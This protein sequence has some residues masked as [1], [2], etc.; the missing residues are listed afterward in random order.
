MRIAGAQLGAKEGFGHNRQG[1]LHHIVID[2]A[3][4]AAA[5]A[6]QH[7]LGKLHHR[8]GIAFDTFDVKGGLG[9]PSLPPPKFAITHQQPIAQR[10][11]KH[12]FGERSFVKF[13]GLFHQHLIHGLWRCHCIHRNWAELK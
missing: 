6:S 5:P 7:L 4:F 9:Q 13:G 12:P 2:L 11:P 1:Q 3:H 8:L 10:W